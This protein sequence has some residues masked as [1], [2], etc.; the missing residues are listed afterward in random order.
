MSDLI[1]EGFILL[2]ICSDNVIISTGCDGMYFVVFSVSSWLGMCS[3]NYWTVVGSFLPMMRIQ[4]LVLFIAVKEKYHGLLFFDWKIYDVLWCSKYCDTMTIGVP[5]G[6]KFT[7]TSNISSLMKGWS[8]RSV[9][10]LGGCNSL[11]QTWVQNLVIILWQ[12]YFYFHQIFAYEQYLSFLMC[13]YHHFIVA[14][15]IL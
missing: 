10:I 15:M 6:G 9:I 4:S 8:E 12:N 7:L 13:G 14:L 11:W 5:I 2:K 1:E 3:E